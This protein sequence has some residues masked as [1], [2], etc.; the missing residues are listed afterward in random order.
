M[1]NF[2][3]FRGSFTGLGR[4]T[5]EI[6]SKSMQFRV[7]FGA[8]IGPILDQFWP[9]GSASL[10]LGSKREQNWINLGPFL[11]AYGRQYPHLWAKIG[12][13]FRI[14]VTYGR[15]VP[16]FW[17]LTGPNFAPFGAKR[18]PTTAGYPIFGAEGSKNLG[19]K[20]QRTIGRRHR[21]VASLRRARAT[22]RPQGR[23]SS[24]RSDRHHSTVTNNFQGLKPLRDARL[25]L[26]TRRLKRRY[27]ADS[28]VQGLEAPAG[29]SLRCGYAAAAQ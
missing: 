25:R 17:A 1:Q 11:A 12:V 15:R 24:L 2:A 5:F 22:T 13:I 10:G 19:P 21:R 29:R 4:R 27:T 20:V 26:A 14:L 9:K 3:F 16:L 28:T 18:R 8:K 7:K 6:A 23:C